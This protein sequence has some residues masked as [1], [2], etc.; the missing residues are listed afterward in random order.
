MLLLPKC[1]DKLR[2]PLIIVKYWAF[3]GVQMSL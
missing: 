2:N 3:F 1:K